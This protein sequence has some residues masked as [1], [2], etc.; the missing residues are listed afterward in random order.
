MVTIDEVRT[1]IATLR[2]R[3]A[4]LSLYSVQKEIG[5]WS[6]DVREHVGTLEKELGIE[7]IAK[8]DMLATEDSVLW[9]RDAL[10]EKGM[11]ATPVAIKKFLNSKTSLLTIQKILD[12]YTRIVTLEQVREAVERLRARGT[13]MSLHNV[14]LE[15]GSSSGKVRQHIRTIEKETGVDIINKQFTL[16]AAVERAVGILEKRGDTVTPAAVCRVLGGDPS[17][18]PSLPSIRAVLSAIYA[19][20]KAPEEQLEDVLDVDKADKIIDIIMG[21][22][23]ALP[24]APAKQQEIDVT[25]MDNAQLWA[26]IALVSDEMKRRT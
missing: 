8:K 26:L 5:S 3:N 22:N 19:Q 14:Q 20:D 23:A 17:R 7:I 4:R 16:T 24:T 10:T 15:V 9:A 21:A 12:G 6:A 2:D 11:E 13:K 18:D 25:A 1:A